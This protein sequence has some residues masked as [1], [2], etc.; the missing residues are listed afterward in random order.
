MNY[1]KHYDKLIETRKNRVIQEDV[2]YEKH[3]ILPRSMG[4]NNDPE[5][6]I[7][8]TAREH[9]LAHWLLWRIYRN[10]STACAFS[11]MSRGKICSSR[12]Y[13]E[14]REA[15]SISQ[16]NNTFWKNVDTNKLSKSTSEYNKKAWNLS[17]TE[18][19]EKA[20]KIWESRRKNGTHH[21][22]KG[23]V[24]SEE[25]RKNISKAAKNRIH[26]LKEY[27]CP[28]CNKTGKGSIML[29]WHFDNCKQILCQREN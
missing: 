24:I 20:R 7:L 23:I 11:M 16:M 13:K 27:K 1:Q 25:G 9:F 12:A 2:Y 22:R 4:G 3:H 14:I 26:I 8:L 17:K 29:R 10:R 15:L 19:S 28:Y 21:R 6:L 18:R 5:N